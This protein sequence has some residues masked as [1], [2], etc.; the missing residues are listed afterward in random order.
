MKTLITSALPYANGQIHIGHL[1]EYIQTDVYSRFMK[2]T[3]EDA[4]YMCASDMHGTPIEVNAQKHGMKPLEFANSNHKK[5][6]EVF[7]KFLVDFDNFYKTHSKENE[8]LSNYFFNTLKKNGHIYK[9]KI[10]V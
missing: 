9:K 5:N 8:E 10:K 4:I 2:L 3:G 1:I 6:L 7:K